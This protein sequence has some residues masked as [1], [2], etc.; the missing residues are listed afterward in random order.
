MGARD[1]VTEEV[2]KDKAVVLGWRTSRQKVGHKVGQYVENLNRQPT[3]S[4]N[5]ND[6]D[7][8]F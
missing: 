6:G 3:K 5:A 1:P 4:E 7:K 2:G 8:H